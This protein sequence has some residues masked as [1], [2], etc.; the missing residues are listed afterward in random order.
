MVHM[1]Q[2]L[3]AYDME[4][5][6]PLRIPLPL[7]LGLVAGGRAGRLDS[8]VVSPSNTPPSPVTLRLPR[9]PE[10]RRYQD[11]VQA[12][13]AVQ[14]KGAG[15]TVAPAKPRGPPPANV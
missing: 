10:R 14:P 8:L 12:Q 6:L 1:Y 3:W 9:G 7:P 4:H 2:F 13:S 5:E 11:T 15:G